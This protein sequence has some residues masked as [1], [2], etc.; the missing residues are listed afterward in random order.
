MKLAK[1]VLPAAF[2]LLTFIDQSLAGPLEN[3]KSAHDNKDYSEAL[4]L[5]PPFAEEG[6]LANCCHMHPDFGR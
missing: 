4:S 5:W 1:I 3:A 6:R 2:A